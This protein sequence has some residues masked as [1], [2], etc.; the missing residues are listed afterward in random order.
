MARP[1]FKIVTTTAA[2]KAHAEALEAAIIQ[3]RLA[4]CVQ[5]WP[6]R[7]TYWWKGRTETAHEVILT[8]KTRARL[9]PALLAF[10]KAHHTYDIP[11]IIV[12]PIQD[13]YP[14]YLGWIRRETTQP[15]LTFS[16]SAT[17][18]RSSRKTGTS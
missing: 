4:A 11:E 3:A 9:V 5:S 6:I 7:S 8:C 15:R 14:A 13:G 1:E 10:I 16:P 17:R 2:D 12:T 18:K